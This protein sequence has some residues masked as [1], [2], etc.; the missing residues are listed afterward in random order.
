MRRNGV[1]VRTLSQAAKLRWATAN[2]TAERNVNVG[3]TL[4]GRPRSEE[5][6]AKI[7][8]GIK[9]WHYGR[10]VLRRLAEAN[11]DIPLAHR[12]ALEIGRM[13]KG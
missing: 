7:S 4:A 6:K 11:I 10:G 2:G 3:R 9:L 5:A 12:S 1:P 8:R 13:M